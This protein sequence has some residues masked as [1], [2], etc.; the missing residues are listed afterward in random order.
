MGAIF[1]SEL[2]KPEDDGLI[3]PEAGEWSRDKHHFL[4][5]YIDAFTTSMRK[6]RWSGLHYIDLFAGA[7]IARLRK[8]GDLD[9]GS[10]L[11]AAQA[12]FPF[13]GLH[14]SERNEENHGALRDR[15]S[16]LRPKSELSVLHGDANEAV[17]QIIKHI[18]NR[19]LSL[20]FL[21][22]YGLHLDY[23]TLKAL[24]QRRSDLI[25]FF[26]DRLDADRNWRKYYWDNP[27]SNLD[28]VLGPGADWR[29][30]LAQS[31]AHRRTERLLRLYQ[32]QIAN[33]GYSEFEWEPIPSSGA[34]L[35][36]LIFC[37]HHETG[38]KIW[39]GT[40]Q[41]KPDNQ[42]TFDFGRP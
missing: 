6:K 5:R 42:Q 37:S 24:A 27:D 23:L 30:E 7:G 32:S 35:Y 1:M 15:L 38:S 29:S 2:P 26:P 36:W 20:A 4:W 34:R 9:W 22:P 12:R 16:R 31:P 18:P 25:I 40:S 21:D 11:I 13:D 10:P 17:H 19:S 8:S 14:F 33:L 3:I 28:R 39:R 41:K